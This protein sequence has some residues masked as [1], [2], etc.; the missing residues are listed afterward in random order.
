M[1]TL[2]TGQGSAPLVKKDQILFVDMW[3]NWILYENY[4]PTF[5]SSV[6]QFVRDRQSE[7]LYFNRNYIR[8]YIRK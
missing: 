2:N 5:D 4:Y 1:K 7:T 3:D 8:Q 6:E